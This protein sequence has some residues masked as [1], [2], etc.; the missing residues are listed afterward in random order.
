MLRKIRRNRPGIVGGM[1]AYLIFAALQLAPPPDWLSLIRERGFDAVLTGDMRLRDLP[2]KRSRVVIVDIDR[3]T[4]AALGNWP[5]PR[6][7]MAHLVNTVAAGHPTALA[8]DILFA[9]PDP[10][11]P[12][13]GQSR[14]DGSASSFSLKTRESDQRLAT[15]IGSAPT[16][17][18]AT[19]DR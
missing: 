2:P 6:A 4:L 16:V 13:A 7:T 17:L 12:D 15:A 8:I 1:I 11:S 19:L 5:W 10:H 14:P 18:G 3:P 9:G